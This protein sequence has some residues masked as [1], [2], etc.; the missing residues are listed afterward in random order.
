M[1]NNQFVVSSPDGVVEN[2]RVVE[3]ISFFGGL[4]EQ[5]FVELLVRL[6]LH[7]VLI[8][9]LGHVLLPV[10]GNL[11]EEHGIVVEDVE[12]DDDVDNEGE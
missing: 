4:R 11:Q 8:F 5:R 6:S 7:L 2:S 10:V 12:E 9:D 3:L 1:F